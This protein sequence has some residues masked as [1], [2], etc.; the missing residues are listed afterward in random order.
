[1]NDKDI[2]NIR[3]E[4]EQ[5]LADGLTGSS[6]EALVNSAEGSMRY[7]TADKAKLTL[8]HYRYLLKYFIEGTPD[9]SRRDQ[10]EAVNEETRRLLDNYVRDLYSLTTP[11]LYYNTLRTRRATGAPTLEMLLERVKALSGRSSLFDSVLA[12]KS[13]EG[14]LV[15]LESLERDI[16]E[17]VW[18]CGSMSKNEVR[19]IE[20]MIADPGYSTGL[21]ALVVSAVWLGGMEFH[22]SR[23][24]ELLLDIYDKSSDEECKARAVVGAVILLWKHRTRNLPASVRDRLAH[25]ED[26]TGWQRDVLT[27]YI[28]MIR[29][30]GSGNLT[31]GMQQDLINRIRQQGKDFMKGLDLSNINLASGDDA[32]KALFNPEWESI[33]ED[34]GIKEKMMELGKLQEEGTD[35]F[36]SAFANLKQFPFFSDISNWFLPFREEHSKYERGS[37]PLPPGLP[38][39]IAGAPFLCD[40]D[41]YST[42]FALSMLPVAQSKALFSHFEAG[43]MMGAEAA[44]AVDLARPE[45][46]MKVKINNY[47]ISLSRFYGM[48]RRKGEFDSPFAA[49][50]DLISLPVFDNVFSDPVTVQGIA[51]FYFKIRNYREALEVFAHADK[52]LAPDASRSQKMGFC[53]ERLGNHERAVEYYEQADL[54]E[55]D[56]DWTLRRMAVCLVALKKHSTALPYL[57]SLLDLHPDEEELLL[58]YADCLLEAGKA[59]EALKVLQK[60]DFLYPGQL[61]TVRL[62]AKSLRRLGEHA[63]AREKYTDILAAAIVF[64]DDYRN[65]AVN[66]WES[67]NRKEALNYFVLMAEILNFHPSTLA[68]DIIGFCKSRKG[69]PK[70][71]KVSE[72][73][74]SLMADAAR[75]ALAA[76]EAAADNKDNN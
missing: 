63:K 4:V 47:A 32:E 50:F 12:G 59:E 37:Q 74:W 23:R 58:N 14:N 18:T 20:E 10:L 66:E 38:A 72:E 36:G 30:A 61:K 5:L 28:E 51:E 15:K 41:K 52:S 56:N 6:L 45:T 3:K 2:Q 17:F 7:E 60:A 62:L 75:E 70:A 71:I 43:A 19:L 34:S 29:T 46:R 21:K 24:L 49:T 53:H 11:T 54:L 67:G 33:L 76:K 35:V 13:A 9:P 57:R 25:L 44:S 65:M 68:T 69:T 31:A 39:A 64:P 73:E 42:I 48:F 40:S 16:F 26:S 1:M 22:D 55:A 8:S 27:T